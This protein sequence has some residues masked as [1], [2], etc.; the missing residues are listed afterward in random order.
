MHSKKCSNCGNDNDPI[1][2]NCL[3]CKSPLPTI[4]LNSLTNE[5]LVLNAAE[6][7][8]KLKDGQ[9]VSKSANSNDF[10]G[11]GVRVI[12]KGEIQGYSLKYLSLLEIRASTNTNLIP[13]VNK[14]R[15]DYEKHV[16]ALSRNSKAL[17]LLIL[18]YLI[19]MVFMYLSSKKL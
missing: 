7:I 6:W 16:K 10:T 13:T 3:F 9:Y 1:L 11:K 5:N 4:D 8:G 12:T 2:T 14:L 15:I 17:I 19:W 18:V